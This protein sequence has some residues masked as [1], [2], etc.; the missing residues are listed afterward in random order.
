M[1]TI[2]RGGQVVVSGL[3]DQFA[4]MEWFH[5]NCSQSMDWMCQW[6]GYAVAKMT[7][8]DHRQAYLNLELSIDGR[9]PDWSGDYEGACKLQE[10][11]TRAHY[12]YAS[13]IGLG[14]VS[15]DFEP[16]QKMEN[17]AK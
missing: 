12:H 10:L 1:Y 15:D 4:V 17:S 2:K 11:R 8:E 3:A 9:L 5:K 14:G 16:V 7:E 13:S 6:E